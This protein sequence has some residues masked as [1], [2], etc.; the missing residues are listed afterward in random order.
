MRESHLEE[1]LIQCAKVR[2]G[3]VRKAKWIGRRGAPDRLVLL[4]GRHFFVELKRPG[5]YATPQQ[6]REHHRLRAAGFEV[7][8]FN[9]MADI[10]I[11]FCSIPIRGPL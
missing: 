3:E 10:N 5:K 9:E 6:A 8:V 7:Y 2:G 4:P 11:F 1:H